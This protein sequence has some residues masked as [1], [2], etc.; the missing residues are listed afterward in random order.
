M[1]VGYMRVS[2]ADGSQA[3]DLQ[4]DAL[5]K[6]GVDSRHLYEDAASGKRDDRP[7]LTACLKALRRGEPRSSRDRLRALLHVWTGYRLL[8]M[9]HADFAAL[10]RET[11]EGSDEL[12]A[13]R[14]ARGRLATLVRKLAPSHRRTRDRR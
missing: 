5:R 6:A 14:A 10:Q 11:G 7:G 1:L 12:R 9:A 8:L 4:R 3:T 13:I 2:K